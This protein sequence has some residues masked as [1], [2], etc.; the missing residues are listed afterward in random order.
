MFDSIKTR[1]SDQWRE[2]ATVHKNAFSFRARTTTPR[3][4]F[5]WILAVLGSFLLSEIPIVSMPQ[6][7][8][9]SLA[10]APLWIFAFRHGVIGGTFAG[11]VSGALQ[12]FTFGYSRGFVVES[13]Q[14]ILDYPLA[15]ATSGVAGAASNTYAI[16]TTLISAMLRMIC[17]IISGVIY[18]SEYA[19]PPLSPLGYSMMYNGAFMIPSM[20]ISMAAALS[21]MLM[22][23]HVRARRYSDDH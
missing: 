20:A 10:M 13:I 4:I 3:L 12:M 1:S 2:G 19:I 17:H 6:G 21:M 23:Q 5:E 9:V 16:I 8:N 14:G 7:G 22:I 11:A 15:F 18:F